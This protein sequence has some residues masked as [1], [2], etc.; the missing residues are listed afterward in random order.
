MYSPF[1]KRGARGWLT[2]SL[3]A[4]PYNDKKIM[5]SFFYSW[6]MVFLFQDKTEAISISWCMIFLLQIFGKT[7]KNGY[8]F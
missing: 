8:T 6:S 5:T 1:L 4:K 3:E 7:L 2:H